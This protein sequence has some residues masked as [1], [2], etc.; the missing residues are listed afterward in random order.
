MSNAFP[1]TEQSLH[2]TRTARR[3]RP[4]S[5]STGETISAKMGFL[6]GGPTIDLTC[7]WARP[8]PRHC[9]VPSGCSTCKCEPPLFWNP[10]CGFQHLKVEDRES[11]PRPAG[12]TA[13]LIQACRRSSDSSVWSNLQAEQEN[14]RAEI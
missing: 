7:P 8:A 14:M 13:A 6:L 10:L 3:D 1:K 11:I 2:P 9:L 4:A 12:R 5:G